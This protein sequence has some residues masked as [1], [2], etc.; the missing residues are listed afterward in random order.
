M[1]GARAPATIVVDAE[2]PGGT[3]R[4]GVRGAPRTRRGRSAPR[5]ARTRASGRRASAAPARARTRT[6]TRA[7]RRSPGGSRARARRR[8]AGAAAPRGSRAGARRAAASPA[9]VCPQNSPQKR[10]SLVCRSGIPRSHARPWSTDRSGSWR[11]RCRCE[12]R[13]VGPRP[14][15]AWKRSSWP[16]TSPATASGS[17]RSSGRRSR[18]TWSPTPRLGR[19]RASATPVSAAA[20]QTIRLVLVTIP[21]SCASKMPRLTPRL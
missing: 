16:C 14:T 9:S 8:G 7:R 13:C 4:R 20:R 19:E 17:V 11:C 15:S 3:T 2:P 1:F 5:R 6:T 12:S 21:R 18:S 10:A